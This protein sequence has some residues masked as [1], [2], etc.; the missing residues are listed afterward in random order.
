M[1]NTVVLEHGGAVNA[2]GLRAPD[3]PVRHKLLDAIGDLALVGCP[4]QGR[5]TVHRGGH[6]LHHALLRTWWE[7]IRPRTSSA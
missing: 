5:M 1:D 3:E 7:R 6:R 2:E 4:V